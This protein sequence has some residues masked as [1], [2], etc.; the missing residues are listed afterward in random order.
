MKNGT[1]LPIITLGGSPTSVATPPVSESRASA[2]SRGVALMRVTLAIRMV[3]GAMMTTVVTLSR[4]KETSVVTVPSATTSSHGFPLV[5]LA[6]DNGQVFEESGLFQDG[7]DDH[8]AGQQGQGM[9]VDGLEGQLRGIEPEEMPEQ[10][11]EY[12]PGQGDDGA[13][14]P[15]AD[16]QDEGDNEDGRADES[17]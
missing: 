12:R 8:H 6:C 9:E 3:M 2:I 13:V 17:R 5:F 10:D 1:A 16:D 4:M 14:H 11:N 15:F 7:H